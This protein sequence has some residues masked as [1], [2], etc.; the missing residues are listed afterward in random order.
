MMKKDDAREKSGAAASSN[1][2]FDLTR[3]LAPSGVTALPAAQGT[4][5]RRDRHAD[6]ECAVSGRRLDGSRAALVQ[7]RALQPKAERRISL[8]WLTIGLRHDPPALSSTCTT[9]F[10]WDD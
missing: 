4:A 5:A 9:R 1:L 3:D 10:D 8:N 2:W 6:D 7:A